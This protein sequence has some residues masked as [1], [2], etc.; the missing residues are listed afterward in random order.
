[1][2]DSELEALSL[3]SVFGV[4]GSFGGASLSVLLSS[5]TSL[6]SPSLGDFVSVSVF[7]DSQGGILPEG[8]ELLDGFWLS[9]LRASTRSSRRLMVSL[10]SASESLAPS[11]LIDSSSI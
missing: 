3:S 7:P 11:F 6:R 2:E 4:G 9:R 10:V 8:R 5:S 1:L